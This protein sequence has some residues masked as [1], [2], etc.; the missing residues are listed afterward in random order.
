MALVCPRI[1]KTDWKLFLLFLS[2]KNYAILKETLNKSKENAGGL[3]MSI[4]ALQ[5][6]I[7]K[8]KSALI[9][10]M[11]IYPGNT[12]QGSASKMDTSSMFWRY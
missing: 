8:R 3:A 2:D 6:K 9:V 4:D 1:E 10:D 12:G 5:E 11:T 7:R